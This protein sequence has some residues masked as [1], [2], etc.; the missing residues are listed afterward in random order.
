MMPCCTSCQ[1]FRQIKLLIQ[2]NISLCHF[3]AGLE[4]L[5]HVQ[6]FV[7]LSAKQHAFGFT[8][9]QASMERNW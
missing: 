4:L 2:D 5:N 3:K 1:N 7:F 8:L 6:P 9:P